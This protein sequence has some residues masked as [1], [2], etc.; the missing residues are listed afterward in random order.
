MTTWKNE[1]ADILCEL[2]GKAW[3]AEELSYFR[4]TIDALS[5]GLHALYGE[6]SEFLAP[7]LDDMLQYLETE[8]SESIPGGTAKAAR[9][10]L[11]IVSKND[12]CES[13]DPLSFL[14]VDL[15][16]KI[17]MIVNAVRELIKNH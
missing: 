3:E 6:S 10:L 11:S 12:Y 5:S 17:D 2:E 15:A 9:D 13:E 8:H 16:A 1:V 4:I 14:S 7:D